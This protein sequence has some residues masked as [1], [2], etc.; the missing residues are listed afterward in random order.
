MLNSLQ[1]RS[2]AIFII[3]RIICLEWST[4]NTKDWTIRRLEI[5]SLKC[6][7]RSDA[8]THCEVQYRQP[9][10]FPYNKLYFYKSEII[11]G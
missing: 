9:Q 8:N 10:K 7:S 5:M 11:I 6:T 4:T 2:V 3:S 1:P